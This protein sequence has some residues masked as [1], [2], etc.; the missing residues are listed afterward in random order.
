MFTGAR[1]SELWLR[2]GSGSLRSLRAGLPAH[3]EPRGAPAA[4][5]AARPPGSQPPGFEGRG[6]RATPPPRGHPHPAELLTLLLSRCPQLRSDRGGLDAPPP[7]FLPRQFCPG[8]AAAPDRTPFL[9]SFI[10]FRQLAFLERL[11]R[12]PHE[13]SPTFRVQAPGPPGSSGKI[14]PSARSA[15]LLR[16]TL[17]SL[18]SGFTPSLA[19]NC[20]L[21][22]SPVKGQSVAASGD[23]FV[24]EIKGQ[25]ESGVRGQSVAR[26][27]VLASPWQG[28]EIVWVEVASG[29]STAWL[30]RQYSSISGQSQ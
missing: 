22:I 16:P 7:R 17:L 30:N 8:R 20:S 15:S 2:S 21:V 11:R 23:H 5:P 9:P 25:S 18:M 4:L 10:L 29:Q 19:V 6:A 27:G 28:L 24:T 3:P 1:M 13:A 26:I 12:A 14:P